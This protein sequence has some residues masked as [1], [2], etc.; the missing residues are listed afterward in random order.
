MHFAL[1]AAAL[2][3]ALGAALTLP[4]AHAAEAPPTTR[5]SAAADGSQADAASE[6]PVI[7]RNGRLAVFASEASNL[8]P[9][10]TDNRSDIFVRDLR[11]GTVKRIAI[12]G[13]AS[14][15]PAISANGRY[16]AFRS[17]T[18]YL[19][20][21]Y[22]H[23]RVTRKTERVDVQVPDGY[24][25]GSASRPA[26]SGDGRFVAFSADHPVYGEGD[27]AH[28]YV[29][30]RK[31]KQTE[32][33][34]HEN[35]DWQKRNAFTPT[36]SDDGRFVA[37]QYNF[38]QPPMPP[39]WGDVYVRDRATGKLVQV[40]A[41]TDG[42]AAERESMNPSISADGR[43]VVFESA[44]THLV[45]GDDDD[46]WNVFVHHLAT[47]R[48]Q[49][50]HGPQGGDG[51]EYTRDGRISANG[52]YVLFMSEIEDE[53][54]EFGKEYPVYLHDLTTGRARMVS[55]DLRGEP[56]YAVTAP[57]A[58]SGDGRVVGYSSNARDI[59]ADDTNEEY[60]AFVHTLN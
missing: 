16:V 56:A 38:N 12:A 39:D 58:I 5:V 7:S 35:P 15:Q 1:R 22:V 48:N 13:Q 34:S 42:A 45:P 23:D 9:G 31:A 32:R 28:I 51:A 55:E 25:D 11:T 53:N 17:A 10:D 3:T 57:G 4:T 14:D 33:I 20:R 41:T 29:R 21:V 37:Y 19:G 36:I 30:D 46:S 40:D 49:R 43:R 54:S 59:V 60:D 47:G 44:D 26:I 2:T 24:Q 6:A 8:V 27:G 50:L 18:D 52:R